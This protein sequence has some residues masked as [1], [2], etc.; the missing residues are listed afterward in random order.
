MLREFNQKIERLRDDIR[1]IEEK[2]RIID[3]SIANE[4]K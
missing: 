2:I 4:K 1:Q 3:S